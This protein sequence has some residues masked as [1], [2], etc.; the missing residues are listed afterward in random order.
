MITYSVPEKFDKARRDDGASFNCPNGHSLSY[1]KSNLDIANE[2]IT[3]LETD[4]KHAKANANY[5]QNE[6][7]RSERRIIALKG[8]LTRLR[9]QLNK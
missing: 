9:N 2:K 5:W 1:S 6:D 4:L 3:K 8:H 7:H